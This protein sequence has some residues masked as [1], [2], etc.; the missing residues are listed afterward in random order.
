MTRVLLCLL[1]RQHVPN[2][3]SVHHFRPDRLVLVE[4]TAMAKGNAAKSFLKALEY[5]GIDYADRHDIEPLEAEDDLEAIRGAL[6]RAYG[7]YPTAQWIANVTGGTKPM[8]IAAYEFFKATAGEAIYTNA[9]RPNEFLFLDSERREQCDYKLSIREFL[10]GYGFDIRRKDEKIC[11]AE[12]RARQWAPCARLIAQEASSRDI[13]DLSDSDRKIARRKGWNIQV[14]QLRA[15]SEEIGREIGKVFS[16]TGEPQDGLH[17]EIDKYAVDF[18]TGGWLEVFFWDSLTRHQKAL[19]IWDVRLGLEVG[20]PGDVSGNEFDVTFMRD[21]GLGMLECKSGSQSHDQ[22]G[23]VLYKVEA[24]TRQFGALRVQSCLATTAENI[25][26]D[27]ELKPSIK[28]RAE[29]YRCRIIGASA[30]RKIA[31]SDSV[32][33][34]R[35]LLFEA[36]ER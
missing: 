33:E 16:L 24:V 8:S 29:I 14:G 5:G 15:P 11:Q 12:E 22:G 10:A 31:K 20:R 35:Q 27:G 13:L 4:S 30:I 1:S 17:G 23:D 9:N 28:N 26:R 2:L 36:K 6:R 34:L 3:L 7:K 18:L 32:E 19:G 21:Y 25:F